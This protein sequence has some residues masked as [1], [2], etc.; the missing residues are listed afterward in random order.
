MAGTVGASVVRGEGGPVG[1]ICR[2]GGCLVSIMLLTLALACSTPDDRTAAE[3]PPATVSE[4]PPAA[5]APPPG[6]LVPTPDAPAP[7]PSVP[8]PPSTPAAP[9]VSVPPAPVAAVP[10]APAAEPAPA[11]AAT[12]VH[13]TL[14]TTKSRIY[15]QVFKDPSTAAA[16]LS[17]DHVV[18]AT[19]WTGSVT[20][21]PADPAACAVVIDVPV[22]GLDNDSTTW[23]K[24]VG[25][26]NELTDGQ[27]ADV[28]K[29]MLSAAQLDADRFPTIHYQSTRCVA[30]GDRVNVT[31]KLTIHGV[32][33]SLTVPMKMDA[34]ATSLS[35]SGT[36]SAKASDFGFEP[37]RA[38][39]GAL[40]NRDT[41][42][43]T[44][45]VTGAP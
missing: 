43:F 14:S 42:K 22:A 31:G 45:D 24:R 35:A 4:P 41:M 27:R 20:W 9:P 8:P 28:K 21:N 30:A 7:P 37:Y 44:I 11:P 3:A 34:T 16:G 1:T 17:H 29:T 26:D 39:L 32:G 40:K 33:K 18:V 13:Y 12:A 38:M 25:Y 15:V 6:P 19:G 23:R 5:T 2:D 36:F 10:T